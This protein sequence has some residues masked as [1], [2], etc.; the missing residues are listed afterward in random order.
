M[1]RT[2]SL[3]R[4]RATAWWLRAPAPGHLE[5]STLHDNVRTRAP[6]TKLCVNVT[7]FWARR[8]GVAP[9]ATRTAYECC[10]AFVGRHLVASLLLSSAVNGAV[11]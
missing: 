5:T 10:Q 4:T 11:P 9:V 2:G 1:T 7:G 8:E 6:R 3:S